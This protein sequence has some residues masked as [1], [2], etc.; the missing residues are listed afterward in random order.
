[1]HTGM[2]WFD[3]APDRELKSKVQSALDYYRKKFNR[4]PNLCL[5][6]PGMITDGPIQLGRLT[7]RGY[8]PVLPHHLWIGV[9]D[10]A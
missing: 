7:I 1:M 2:L 6:N 4:E 9:E 3:N 8:A 5:V 10:Q